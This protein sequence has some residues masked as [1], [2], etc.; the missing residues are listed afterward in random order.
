MSQIG[1]LAAGALLIVAGLGGLMPLLFNQRHLPGR[2]RINESLN[3]ALSVAAGVM[4]PMPY[5]PRPT[6]VPMGAPTARPTVN[7]EQAPDVDD[8]TH[9]SRFGDGEVSGA[10]ELLAQLFTIRMSMSD[11]VEEIHTLRNAYNLDD[12]E[13][14][15]DI[16][17]VDDDLSDIDQDEEPEEAAVP[18]ATG[19]VSEA[20]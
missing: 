14:V 18:R 19:S 12:Y 3:P 11:L 8:L 15:E 1:V 5:P 7:I 17:D 16:D 13:I 6:G 2:L 10:E 9:V 4:R 20:A